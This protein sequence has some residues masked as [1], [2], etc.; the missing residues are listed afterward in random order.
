MKSLF[1]ETI[2]EARNVGVVQ[3]QSIIAYFGKRDGLYI[4]EWSVAAELARQGLTTT[5]PA[6]TYSLKVPPANS[7]TDL[8]VRIAQF[9]DAGFI[10]EACLVQTTQAKA[11]SGTLT[12]KVGATSLTA[13]A[14]AGLVDD[15]TALSLPA[16]FASNTAITIVVGTGGVTAGAFTIFLR[17]YK[18]RA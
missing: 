10:A 16:A 3:D 9:I 1:T 13:I 11:G 18:G 15:A 7:A 17:G 2:S 12:P 5:L 8:S 4:V 14:G 6:G